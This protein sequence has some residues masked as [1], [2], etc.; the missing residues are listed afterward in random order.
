MMMMIW[1]PQPPARD[2]IITYQYRTY[3]VNNI[4]D[5]TATCFTQIVI[6]YIDKQLTRRIWI[7]SYHT[8]FKSIHLPN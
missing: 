6:L 1:H 3:M 2:H 4:E 7:A 8:S 5:K